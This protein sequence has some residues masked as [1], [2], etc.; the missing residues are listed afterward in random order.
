MSVKINDIEIPT[1]PSAPPDAQAPVRH[2]IDE[3]A[4]KTAQET[5]QKYIDGKANLDRRLINNE[6]WWKLQHWKGFHKD[7]EERKE[8]STRSSTSTRMRWTTIRLR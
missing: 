5:L 7:P 6:D 4:I 1:T 3:V 2:T 8:Q